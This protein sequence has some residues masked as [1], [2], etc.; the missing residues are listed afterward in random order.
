MF[1][2]MLQGGSGG[3]TFPK[4]EINN[5]VVFAERCTIE[6]GGYFIK[7]GVCFADVSIKALKTT[8]D[9]Q[10]PLEGFPR[11][12]NSDNG[13]RAAI[14]NTVNGTFVGAKIIEYVSSTGKT[15]LDCGLTIGQNYRVLSMYLTDEADTV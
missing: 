12:K 5:L 14:Y 8:S 4:Y 9:N 7:D 3:D 10:S 13:I 15:F 11:P 6:N 1:Q 2:K